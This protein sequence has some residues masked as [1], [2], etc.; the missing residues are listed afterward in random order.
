[1]GN[2]IAR[3]AWKRGQYSDVFHSTIVDPSPLKAGQKVKVIWGETRKELSAVVTCYPLEEEIHE[4]S[5]EQGDLP[6]RQA[7]AKRKLVSTC[8]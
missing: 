8:L 2:K 6:S 1:M 5:E 4:T 3:I 7:R